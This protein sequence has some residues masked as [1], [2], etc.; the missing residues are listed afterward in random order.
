MRFFL[1]GVMEYSEILK[2]IESHFNFKSDKNKKEH[3]IIEKFLLN[4]TN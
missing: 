2:R 1:G 3:H 4:I